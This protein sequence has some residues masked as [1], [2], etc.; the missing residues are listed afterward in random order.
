MGWV[1]RLF[2]AAIIGIAVVFA[3]TSMRSASALPAEESAPATPAEIRQQQI[4]KAS[5][6]KPADPELMRHLYHEAGK[7]QKYGALSDDE[8]LALITL[9]PAKQL[10]IDQRVGSIEVGKD[11]DLVIFQNHPL[12]VYGVPQVTI[13]DGVVRFDR[14]KDADDMRLAVDPN[15]PVEA[16]E[17]KQRDHDSCLEGLEGAFDTIFGLN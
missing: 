15:E 4:L 9:N 1:A 5:A 16:V 2:G 8:A 11:A 6:G 17:L 13:V 10:G 7:T 12:S 14:A 3:W